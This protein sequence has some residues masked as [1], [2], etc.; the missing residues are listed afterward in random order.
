MKLWL[1]H[2]QSTKCKGGESC[3]QEA[4]MDAVTESHTPP[5]SS[6]GS[7]KPIVYSTAV[8]IDEYSTEGAMQLWR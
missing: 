8:E 1:F 7:C 5:P 3:G 2:V 6:H 4:R